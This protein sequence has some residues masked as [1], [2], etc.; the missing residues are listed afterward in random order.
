MASTQ[1]RTITTATRTKLTALMYIWVST[2]SQE[3][4][5]QVRMIRQYADDHG[6]E[7]S[8]RFIVVPI[9]NSFPGRK[10]VAVIV[11]RRRNQPIG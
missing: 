8:D 7:K 4:D 9:L 10:S 2:P 1:Q 3:V 5:K 6:A 11:Q